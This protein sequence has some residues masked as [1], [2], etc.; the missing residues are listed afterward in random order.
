MP[1]ALSVVNLDILR[2]IAHCVDSHITLTG[3]MLDRMLGRTDPTN[4]G[5]KDLGHMD[6]GGM[7]SRGLQREH[8]GT[9]YHLCRRQDMPCWGIRGAM[10]LEGH[11]KVMMVRVGIL[12]ETTLLEIS[13]LLSLLIV[14]ANQKVPNEVM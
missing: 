5:G 3:R 4:L 7:R 12:Q 8:T 13:I 14:I 11:L 9:I 2:E 6:H 10:F 1:D